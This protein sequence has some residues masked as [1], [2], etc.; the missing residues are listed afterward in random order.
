MTGSSRE[1]WTMP[2]LTRATG[3]PPPPSGSFRTLDR[4]LDRLA[5]EG[6]PSRIDRA[7]WGD[8]ISG[9]HGSRLM[10]ALRFFS[11][12]DAANEPTELLSRLVEPSTRRGVLAD[13]LRLFY[14]DLIEGFD[15]QRASSE[16][17]AERFGRF[18]M[19]DDE[20]WRAMK[21]LVEAAGYSGIP[22]NRG[23][24]HRQRRRKPPA[25]RPTEAALHPVLVPLLRDLNRLSPDWDRAKRA[26]WL[27]AFEAALDFVYPASG[28]KGAYLV[29]SQ[30]SRA[31]LALH[32]TQSMS[33]GRA[34]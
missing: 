2:T 11:L 7:F 19:T 1:E 31:F 10:A 16:Q 6:V 34:R 27:R 21:F 20:V 18:A 26:R 4:F 25:P 13:L 15:L 29:A 24:A 22:V 23:L 33:Q 30:P 17:L 9:T 3:E 28:Q 32:R 5:E 8:R 14:A 12:I